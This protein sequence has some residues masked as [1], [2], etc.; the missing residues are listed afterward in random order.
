MR[1][2]LPPALRAAVYRTLAID[3]E[4]RLRDRQAALD[5]T[6]AA[7][8]MDET[9]PAVRDGFRSRRDRLL[10]LLRPDGGLL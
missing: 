1:R 5:Y 9:G 7:L 2:T 6:E 4:W 3:A 10:R 8:G